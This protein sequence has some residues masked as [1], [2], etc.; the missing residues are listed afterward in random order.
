[1]RKRVILF[2]VVAAFLA[3]TL[4]ASSGEKSKTAPDK[5]TKGGEIRAQYV[6]DRI[7]VKFKDD[8]SGMMAEAGRSQAE[9]IHNLKRLKYFSRIDVNV[10]QIEGSVEE[11]LKALQKNPNVAYAEPDY[12]QTIDVTIPNDTSFAQLWGM[13]N[14]GQTGGTVDADIDAPEAWDL[15]A[16]SSSVIVAVIDTGVAYTHPDLGANMWVNPGEI[17][18]NATD[19]DS[20]GYID[21]VYGINSITGSGNPMDDN[22]HGSHC[23]G[24]IAGV[25]NNSLGVAGVCWTARIMALKFL[26]SGGS[27]STSNAIECIEYAINKGAHILSNSWGGSGYTQ[28][29][30][31]AIDA[32]AT[33]G[34]LFCA[35]AGNNLANDDVTP[36]YPAS[37]S[38]PNIVS[39][40]ATDHNDAL[41]IWTPGV[42]GSHWGPFSV[43]VAAPGSS[44]LSTITGDTYASFNGTSMATPHVAGLA[45]LIKSYTFSLN[46]MQI[47]DR[48]LSGAEPKAALL[49]KMQTGARINAYNSLLAGDVASYQVSVQ[50][51]PLT[52]ASI[53]VSPADLDGLSSGTTNFTR[54]YTPYTTVTLTA[55]ATFSGMNFSYWTLQGSRYSGELSISLPIDY[56]KTVVANYVLPLPEAVDNTSLSWV[57]FGVQG[58]WMGQMSTSHT[59]GDAAQS[60]DAADSQ[61]GSM[62]TSV[63]GPGTLTFWWK[64][65]S[66]S[67]NDPLTLYVDGVSQ[68][69]ISGEVDWQQVNLPLAAGL[70]VIRWTFSKNASISTGSDCG[71]VDDVQFS[72]SPATLGQALDQ[73]SLGWTTGE[74]GGWFP[75][76]TTY[77]YDADAV[78]SS[79]IQHSEQTSLSVT[80]SGPTSLSFYW[81]VSSE[82]GYDYL[83]FYIDSVLQT[84]ISGT[85]DW[86]QLNYALG[87]GSHVLS[88]IYSKDASV[89]GGLDCGWVDHVAINP[90][91]T[92]ALSLTK[93]G[94]GGGKVKVGSDPVPHDLP[95]GEVFASG[96]VVGLEAVPDLT[97]IFTAW[98]GDLVSTANPTTITMNQ[99]K[100]VVAGFD[101]TLAPSITVTSPN[102]G[103]S[104]TRSSAHAVTWSQTTMTGTVTIDLHKG[105]SYRKTLGTANA[106]AGTFSWAISASETIGTDYR[107]VIWQGS[108]TDSSDANFGIEA[109]SP[110]LLQES[111]SGSTIPTGWTYQNVGTTTAWTVS[112]TSLAGGSPNEM[113]RMFSGGTLTRLVTPPINTTGRSDVTLSFK[114]FFD[115]WSSG[116]IVLKV[117]TSP[118]GT[119]WTDEAWTVTAGSVNIGP[120]T[121]N[122]ALANNLNISTTYVGFVLAGNL[123]YMDYWYIDDVNVS[124]LVPPIPGRVDFNSDGQED[125]LWRYQGAGD[126]QGWNVVW[127]MNQAQGLSPVSLGITAKETGS[128]GMLKSSVP[129]L[130]RKTPLDARDARITGSRKSALTPM[131]IG[132]SRAVKPKDVL[133]SPIGSNRALRGKGASLLSAPAMKD[134]EMAAAAS[135]GEMKIASLGIDGYLYL[136]TI[137]DLAWEIAG[138]GDFDGDT[139]TDIL[140]RNYGAGPFS[141]WNVVWYM[142]TTGGVDGYG[143]LSG[144]TDLSWRIVGT[145]DFDGDG[146][147]DILWRNSGQGTVSGWNVVWYMNSTGGIDGYGYLTGILDM[148]WKI[149]GTGDFDGD[150]DTDILWR[151]SGQGTFSGWNVIW[152][153]NGE[154]IASYGYLSGISDLA[155]E[156]AGTGDFNNDGYVDILWRNYGAGG[157]QGWNCIWYMQGE[158]II[159]Y[160]Y[161]MAISDTNWRIVNR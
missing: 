115:T 79:T 159:G 1:M 137:T 44:I 129:G 108:V 145:G 85:V 136:D 64:V 112:L 100:S 3:F 99:N 2:A 147:T 76:G 149:V 105:G 154:A 52:G 77:Q 32:A 25:G 156:I 49:G 78:Q 70:H 57:T 30:K 130:S 36:F 81:K 109:S 27:G 95:Y 20:N 28:A 72:G 160:D 121:V 29:L 86:T 87:S 60:K 37:Y 10:Y 117:Q 139:D 131:A 62:Q 74:Y 50:S 13:N 33:A 107:I 143:Y 67:G 125:L 106:T 38:S 93:A 92:Y 55:P 69:S 142:N 96:A 128:T 5:Q 134:A 56:I 119:N 113:R 11:A 98:S 24:T 54:R 151:N 155:W 144:I 8:P 17:A 75:Q 148:D 71:W 88:W 133:R 120:E 7:L 65:S 116:G 123:I 43:D 66:E 58:G 12:I 21:D 68:S 26:D 18:G 34:Q 94:T 89:N 41:S 82:S 45:A 152:Y 161:P 104:W 63:L 35:A 59:G 9:Y 138:T 39:V 118:D 31:D 127:L 80:V 46:W 61:N 157:L 4:I 83:R 122:T 6:P 42:T 84:S 19:D 15:T 40:A 126:Y 23:S 140:W 22:N 135:G 73:Q 102:G 141:G 51:A 114:H 110:I 158:G 48:I 150:G 16:G 153:M 91:G 146:D 103:E 90:A 53:T 111:F 101:S 97:S 124:G 132:K 14:T 47:R